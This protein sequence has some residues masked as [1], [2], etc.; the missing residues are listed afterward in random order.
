MLPYVLGIVFGLTVALLIISIFMFHRAV[1]ERPILTGSRR[2]GDAVVIA[3]ERSNAIVAATERVSPAVVS[4]T[5]LRTELVRDNQWLIH[6]WMNRYFRSSRI[7]KLYREQKYSVFGS[8]VVVNPEGYVLTNEHVIS[9]AESIVVTLEDGTE[10]IAA[11]VGSAAEFDLALLKIEAHDL[12][13]A[14][15]GDSDSLRIG[16][17]VI[18][19][20]SP[21]GYLLNDT[22]PTVTVGVISALG[23]DVKS[24][25]ETTEAVFKNM[26]QTDAAINPGNSGG[27]LVSSGGEVIG[28]NT[29]IFS[30][31]DGSNL[32]MGF[33]IP[34]NV[35]KM[36]IDEITRYGHVRNVWT[37]LEVRELDE[38]M[39]QAHDFAVSKGLYVERIIE[40]SPADIAGVRVGDVI[41]EVN[42]VEIVDTDQAN[43]TIF[44]LRV[45]ET[46]NMRLLRN[47]KLV[48]VDITLAER[49]GQI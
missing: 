5:S 26:I 13:F 17:W 23:R 2:A 48:T 38:R 41:I 40:G 24:N 36:V 7:P 16:E 25:P 4:I 1:D 18:A 19:I 45:G 39:S 34:I 22:Q 33:A 9:G 15:V 27:P 35:A 20:G 12:P 32:G 43:R 42:G 21:F 46:L 31:S 49:P 29:F 6:E 10:V 11:V 47:D 30:A 28:I 44:G 8:G 3:Q 37:G 14:M